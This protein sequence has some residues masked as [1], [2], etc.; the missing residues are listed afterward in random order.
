M[1]F[2]CYIVIL[3]L[4]IKLLFT[5]SKIKKSIQLNSF[6]SQSF[7]L[8]NQMKNNL[9]KCKIVKKITCVSKKN[10]NEVENMYL[11]FSKTIQTKLILSNALIKYSQYNIYY[12]KYNK[13][14]EVSYNIYIFA[15]RNVF[16]SYRGSI[17]SEC[18]NITIYGGC[19]CFYL[20]II[21]TINSTYKVYDKIISITQHWGH[22]VYHS[23]V[24]CLPK[25]GYFIPELLND[26]TIKIHIMHSAS[27]KYLN[28]LGFNNSRLIYGSVIAKQLLVPEGNCAHPP[29]YVQFYS[30]RYYLRLKIKTKFIYDIVLIKRYG[31]R[32]II[33][34]NEVYNILRN[35]FKKY[36]IVI[37]YPNT[38]F[39]DT[40]NYF[41]YAKLIVA[42]HGA[43]LS[44]IIVSNS[45][46]I[47]I[48]FTSMINICYYT[49]SSV[50]GFEYY[51]IYE[52]LAGGRKF[53]VNINTFMH[54]LNHIKI[55]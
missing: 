55:N 47:I 19:K 28:F 22:A 48:E 44:N 35:Y 26:D 42:P 49:L 38:P 18:W 10:I 46:C 5:N 13:T 45:N 36:K 4:F 32:D 33:N 52:N 15:F 37:F 34:F 20:P 23:V 21:H 30:L 8:L 6:L 17:H 12:S 31:K 27:V 54:V 39:D 41:K 53:N 14:N 11:F 2:L 43:G 25:I 50:L 40:L 29:P 3:Y 24:E 51:G 9:K 16:L 1:Y 7:I